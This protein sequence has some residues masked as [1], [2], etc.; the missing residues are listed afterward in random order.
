[1]PLDPKLATIDIRTNWMCCLF[2]LLVTA[3]EPIAS[4][5]VYNCVAKLTSFLLKLTFN[6]SIYY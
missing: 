1:M 6:H 3:S 2:T 5:S 4:L